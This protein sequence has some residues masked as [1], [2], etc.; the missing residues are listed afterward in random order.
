MLLALSTQSF[1]A[2]ED[3]DDDDPLTDCTGESG[4]SNCPE[5]TGTGSKDDLP[6]TP[7]SN[8]TPYTGGNAPTNSASDNCEGS[9]CINYEE[10]YE[11]PNPFESTCAKLFQNYKNMSVF[12]RWGALPVL[13][14]C[15]KT[16]AAKT[17]VLNHLVPYACEAR[18]AAG[19]ETVDDVV[20]ADI[21]ARACD[22]I[23]AERVPFGLG[24]C[25]EVCQDKLKDI[26]SD[27]CP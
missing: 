13:E 2:S 6:A 27:H 20:S 9:G 18:E 26:I 19:V 1:F 24:A 10:S 22:T 16:A 5:V 4:G 14:G 15:G 21:C 17:I 11:N 8:P 12:E 3:D 25:I 23:K 7:N